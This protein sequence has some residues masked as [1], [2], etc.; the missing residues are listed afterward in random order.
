VEHARFESRPYALDVADV[1]GWLPG[2][3]CQ[4]PRKPLIVLVGSGEIISNT[5]DRTLSSDTLGR[6]RYKFLVYKFV[7]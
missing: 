6:W 5:P 7:L 3:G 2:A 4:I 1:L